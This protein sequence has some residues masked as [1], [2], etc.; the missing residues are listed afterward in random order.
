MVLTS[1]L[2]LGSDPLPVLN[3]TGCRSSFHHPQDR[4]DARGTDRATFQ[5]HLEAELTLNQELHSGKDIDACVENFSGVILRALAA[6]TPER[7]PGG[8]PRPQIP[9]GIQNGIRLKNRLRRRWQVTRDPALRAVFNRLHRSVSRRLNVWRKERWKTTLESLNPE[10]EDVQASDENLHSVSPLTTPRG[11]ALSDSVKAQALADSLEA[12]FQPVTVPSVSAVI[13]MVN[14]LLESYLQTPASEPTVTNSE[15][16]QDAIR[17]LK[18]SKDPGPND[19]SNR[20]LKHLPMR[21]VLLLVQIFNS[22]LCTHHFPTAWKHSRVISILKPR[23]DPAQPSLYLPVSLLDT[24]GKL[25]EKILLTRTL[26]QVGEC[27]LLRDEKFWFRPRHSTALQL[28][29]LVERITRNFGERR[30]TGAVFLD[31]AKA[32]VPYGSKASFTS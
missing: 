27:G 21:A 31:V 16:V 22:I 4:P 30:L 18:L 2:A 28:A 26:H 1:C 24:I 32:F 20:A 6:S 11:I 14:V 9:A 10:Y 13:E 29:R 5:T 15:E 3:D 7:R 19:I 12:Q 25:F 23:K 17:G 8:D